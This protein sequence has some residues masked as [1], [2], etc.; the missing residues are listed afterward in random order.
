MLPR[1]VPVES[2][3]LDRQSLELNKGESETLV[4][5]VLPTNAT[6]KTVTWS[7]SNISI[8]DVD[9][10]GVVTATGG[11]SAT[12]TAKAGEKTTTC[13]VTV[14][15]PVES[16]TLDVTSVTLEEWQT[17]LITATVSPSDATNKTVSW[18]SS[19][20]S[21]AS[22]SGGLVT[23]K[24]EGTAV[25]TA[26]AGEKT[27]TCNV[28]VKKKIVAVTSVVLNK[29]S[30]SLNKGESETLV[31]TVYPSN[32]TDKTVS[33]SS[34]DTDIVSVDQTGKVTANGAGTAS[35]TARAGEQSA[36][37]QV[38]VVIPI[39]G[40]ELYDD[41]PSVVRVGESVVWRVKII[42][43]DATET[44]VW[45]VWQEYGDPSCVSVDNN[46]KITGIKEGS[47][48]IQVRSPRGAPGIGT[49]IIVLPSVVPVESITLDY[50]SLTINKGQS[51][52]LNATVYP[53]NATDKTVTWES[54]NPSVASVDQAGS[55]MAKSGGRATI[56]AKAGNHS[57]T[58]NVTV[59][60]PVE[61]VDLGGQAYK[62]LYVG[63]TFRLVATVY[64]E[65][66]TDKTVTWSS[67]NPSVAS[68][69]EGLITALSEGNT[70]I[71][72]KV[73]D[74]TASCEIRVENVDIPVTSISL[75]KMTLVLNKGESETLVA[76]VLPVNATDKTVT[77]ESSD[78]S[79]ATV[80][81]GVVTAVK[82]GMAYVVAKAGNKSASCVVTV[83]K[84]VVPVTHL[85]LNKNGLTLEP[86]QSERLTATVLPEDATDKTVTWQTSD[87]SVATVSDGLVTAVSAGETKIT[88]SCAGI[89]AYCWVTVKTGVIPV[90]SVVLDRQSVTL[91][92]NQSTLLTATVLPENATD[93]TVTWESSD[94]ATATVYD[95]RVTALKEGIAYIVAKAG[96]KSATCVV[97]VKKGV[98]P[99][100]S[101]WISYSSLDMNKGESRIIQAI[102]YPDNATDKT[103][104]WSSSEPS[105]ASVDQT[106]QVTALAGGQAIITAK[107]GDKEANCIVSVSVPVS[108]IILNKTMLKL[109]VGA[110]E[111]LTATVSPVDANESIRWSSTNTAVAMVDNN[112]KV[113]AVSV[114]EAIITCQSGLCAA[115]CYLQ[116]IPN[117]VEGFEDE[118]EE[119]W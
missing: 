66:A 107:A 39:T 82:E 69:S 101:V 44:P 119:E 77:W 118:G 45:S 102:V 75:N 2:I 111:I 10:N 14:T 108:S 1:E 105:V 84:G 112:G 85:F 73:G 58:C 49:S 90:E 25:I 92:E 60:V 68:V 23:A 114:G 97:T 7:S 115:S 40:L 30:I 21:V 61:A 116:V 26:K 106:G 48:M 47:A 5:T 63:D 74:K 81:D 94:P 109:K 76:T 104:T 88:A 42:P 4:A 99:V 80:Y 98:V 24:S 8:A 100:T 41:N 50:T 3:T 32:A 67:S 52:T 13:A 87:P 59:N 46:G 65:D 83:N 20:A 37:C 96:N 17:T 18:S 11:G 56:T 19:N 110:S 113:I 51:T 57:A 16:V 9:Q 35:I 22:V 70:V 36:V 64:P 12:I 71:T 62:L 93:K 33:W 55:V 31:A 79:V 72:A 78:P 117:D 27:A 34:S 6:D 53:Y 89:D 15:V 43:E 91:E 103:I 38:T 54:S 28:T 95:G 29:T 86:G